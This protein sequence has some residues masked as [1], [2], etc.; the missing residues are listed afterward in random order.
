MKHM[1]PLNKKAARIDAYVAA[2]TDDVV[3]LQDGA[4]AAASPRSDGV[5][6]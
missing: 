2:R 6:P 4:Q 3:G 1:R 5:L